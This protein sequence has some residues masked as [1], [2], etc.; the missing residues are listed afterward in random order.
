MVAGA[1]AIVGSG[2]VAGAGAAGV[3]S[4]GFAC[5][6][7]GVSVVAV[8]VGLAFLVLLLKMP[9]KAFFT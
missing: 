3:V 8:A 1:G 4:V 2:A 5:E 6:A 7:A 9:L